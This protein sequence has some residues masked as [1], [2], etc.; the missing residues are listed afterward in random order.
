VLTIIVLEIDASLLREIIIVV[1]A[2]GKP[3]TG[4]KITS[5]LFPDV[6]SEN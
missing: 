4:V 2:F 1:D 3:L 6:G 5:L